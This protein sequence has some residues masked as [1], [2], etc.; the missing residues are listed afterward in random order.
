MRSRDDRNDRIGQHDPHNQNDRDDQNERDLNDEIRFHLAEETRRHIEAG[1]SPADAEA[2]ARR[3]FGNVTLVT[4]VTRGMWG[5]R[6]LDATR[7]DLRYGLRLLARHRLFAIFS[8]ISLALGIGGTSAVFSLF[9][10]IVLRDLPVAAPERLITLSIQ[11]GSRP[12]NSYMPYPQF[13]AMRQDSRFVEGLFARTEAGRLRVGA[14]GVTEV[15]V[16][17][18]VTGSYHGTLGV[19]P[20]L[21]RLLTPADDRPGHATVAVI[22]HAYWQRRFGGDASIVGSTIALN[23]TPFTVVG[24]EPPGF[25]GATLGS[26]PDV[27]MP[28][29]ARDLLT[30]TES[31]WRAAFATWIQIMGRLRG[32]A[33]IEQATQELTSIYERVSIDAAGGAAAQSD[34]ARLA[35]ETKVIVRPGAKGGPSGLRNTY[36]RGLRLL[37][38]MLGGI[39]CLASLNVATLLLARSA[40]RR[41]EIAT[42]LA[43]GADRWRIVRQLLTESAVIAGSGGLLGLLVAWRGSE[44]LLRLATSNTEA[45]PISV[46]P[47]ARV[48]AFTLAVSIASCLLFGVLPAMRATASSRSS[49]SREVSGR[50]RRLLDRT[51]VASQAALSLVLV[52]LAGLFL[53]SLHNL[54]VQ[55]TGYDRR[56]VLMFSPDKELKGMTPPQ[57][58][59]MLERLLDELR[60][61]PGVR[62]A[63]VSTVRPVSDSYYFI[64]RITQLGDRVL[65]RDE[66]VGV[67]FNHLSPGYFSVMNIPLVSGRDFERRDGPEAP[68][69]AIV[70]EKLARRF[71]GNPVGQ[72]IEMGRGNVRE[73]IGVAKDSRY[74]RVK[75]A[76]RDVV[77]MPLFQ[78]FPRFMPSFEVRYEGTAAE[79]LQAATAAAKRVDPALTVVNA[80]TL[81]TETQRSFARERLLALLTTYLGAFALL[82]AGVGLYGLMTCTVAERTR[83]LGLRMALGARPSGIRWSVIGDGARTALFGLVVGLA[84]ALSVVRLTRTLL[85]EVEPVDPVAIGRDG[86]A[87]DAGLRRLLRSGAPRLAHRSDDGASSGVG[88]KATVGSLGAVRCVRSNPCSRPLPPRYRAATSGPTR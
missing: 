7:Q 77:Y 38:M 68:R 20:A 53:R 13:E 47:D 34:D 21:G 14:R 33:T 88:Q 2:A 31:P 82:L 81:E 78:D 59:G 12:G 29:Q 84:G 54:W 28:M 15:A 17:L 66:T 71:A 85:F 87:A 11:S 23:Q 65:T 8:I 24:V 70:S 55:D 1:M 41:E 74:A 51:L 22:S 37:L 36:E 48:I 3:D 19:R 73:V 61:V 18:Q 35:R 27:I 52:V 64:D 60:E 67:A 25:F 58:M 26:A 79:T 6:V 10:A 44:L 76:P 5:G 32:D 80:R 62:A 57:V 69:V 63:A 75:E 46:A 42:R 72:R 4:E 45:L 49:S 39:L 56:N 43:L 86:G 16:G 9:D 50:R 83:E 30:T 40:S